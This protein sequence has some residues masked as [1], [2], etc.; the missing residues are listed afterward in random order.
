MPA[1][2]GETAWTERIAVALD[3]GREPLGQLVGERRLGV[4]VVSVGLRLAVEA[5]PERFGLGGDAPG[6]A[7][8]SFSW[9]SDSLNPMITLSSSTTRVGNVWLGLYLSEASST[10]FCSSPS[11]WSTYTYL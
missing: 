5:V 3:V 2:A 8:L 10:V 1:P 6:G 11:S 4:Q 9:Y 7:Q